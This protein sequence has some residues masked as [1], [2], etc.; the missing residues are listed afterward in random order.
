MNSSRTGF[1]SIFCGEPR[2]FENFWKTEQVPIR[3]KP[4]GAM[5]SMPAAK[6]AK[7]TY[8]ID[9]V[10][11]PASEIGEDYILRFEL[12]CYCILGRNEAGPQSRRTHAVRPYMCCRM[13]L[14]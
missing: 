4:A 3:L 9:R 10:R 14:T 13:K 8:F 6:P 1:R 12:G 11:G 5:S 2:A 7:S